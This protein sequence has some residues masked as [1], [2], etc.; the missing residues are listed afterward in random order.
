MILLTQFMSGNLIL[1]ICL[2]SFIALIVSFIAL[3]RFT[4]FLPRDHGRAYAV[5]GGIS[6]GKPTGAGILFI[7]VF[8]LCALLFLPFSWEYALYILFILFAMLFGYLDDGAKKPWKEYLKGALD[9][10]VSLGTA[11]TFSMFSSRE[12]LLPILGIRYELPL[13]LYVLLAT[14]LVWVSINVTNCTDGVD[15][16]SSSLTIVSLCSLLGVMYLVRTLSPWSGA[17]LIMVAVLIP[18]LW[19]NTNPSQL[20]MG[21][22]GSRAIGV[23]LA[24]AVMQSRV[25]LSYL[26]TCLVFILDGSSGILKISLKRFLRI[27]ILKNTL[28][29]LHDHLRKKM[30][31][32]NQQVTVR[33]TILQALISVLYLAFVYFSK[34]R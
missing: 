6:K 19:F 1:S 2:G 34:A 7:V 21:D 18:Y 23:F 27:S 10:A 14:I 30:N 16:L 13:P 24:I 3:S 8:A 22:A 33:V 26:A 12:V 25:P 9:L 4:F 31:W 17:M 11:L 28:T 5:E 29:P 32:P 15:G 20:L